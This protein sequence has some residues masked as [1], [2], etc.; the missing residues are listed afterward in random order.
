MGKTTGLHEQHT[1]TSPKRTTS[2]SKT[3]IVF[4][5]RQNPLEI[6]GSQ[7]SAQI[8]PKYAVGDHSLYLVCEL[9]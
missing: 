2:S 4:R 7:G 5:P 3:P 1:A 9:Q 6:F 8:I